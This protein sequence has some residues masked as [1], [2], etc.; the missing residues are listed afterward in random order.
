MPKGSDASWVLKLYDKCNESEHFSRPRFSN[1]GFI[2]A[3]F[4]DKVTYEVKGFLDKNRDTVHE[5]Q[6]NILRASKVCQLCPKFECL[7]LHYK[8]LV[9]QKLVLFCSSNC[10]NLSFFR[11]N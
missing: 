9:L 4:A 11:T 7:N 8:R 6:I 3:H 10:F 5:E 2:V 1:M